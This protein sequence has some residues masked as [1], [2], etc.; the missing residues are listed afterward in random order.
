MRNP[1]RIH[2][3]MEK[4]EKLWMKYPDWRLGQLVYNIAGRDPFHIEDYQL[5]KQGYGKFTNDIIDISDSSIPDYY[6]EP[7]GM[8]EFVDS[9]RPSKNLGEKT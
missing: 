2:W 9:L 7:D 1:E 8:K 6:I 3:V 4:L 5:I